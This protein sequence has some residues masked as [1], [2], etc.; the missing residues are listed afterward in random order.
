[1]TALLS[2]LLAV[3]PPI[4]TRTESVVEKIHGV[5]ISDLESRGVTFEDYDM[6]GIK[7]VDHIA[8]MGEDKAAWFT[9]PDGNILCLHQ[10]MSSRM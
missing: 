5:E 9:D 6:P 8:E 1:M 3:V 2:I 10:H 7:T 4:P